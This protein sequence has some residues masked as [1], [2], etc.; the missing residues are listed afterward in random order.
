MARELVKRHFKFPV[1]E[2]SGV[3]ELKSIDEF[4]PVED[5][6]ES[7]N[8]SASTYEKRAVG[9]NKIAS[10]EIESI[11]VGKRLRGITKSKIDELAESISAVGLLQ[12]IVITEDKNLVAG[13]H[14]VEA[15]RQLG[16]IEINAVVIPNLQ[17]QKEIAEIDENLIRNQLTVLEQCEQLKRRKELYEALYPETRR[18]GYARVGFDELQPEDIN[19]N[20][21][22][23]DAF[24]NRAASERKVTPRTIQRAIRI[25][26][27]LDSNVKGQI[28]DLPIAVRF[29]QLMRLAELEPLMQREI[30]AKMS[31]EKLSFP[32]AIKFCKQAETTNYQSDAPNSTTKMNRIVNK[33]TSS[34]SSL[35]KQFESFTLA[36]MQAVI[37][38]LKRERIDFSALRRLSAECGENLA[39]SDLEDDENIIPKQLGMPLT[40]NVAW[41]KN[42]PT[43]DP[44]PLFHKVESDGSRE[45]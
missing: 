39:A 10:V 4:L 9:S 22:V 23:K 43:D 44:L 17:L 15:C 5:S 6:E 25:A 20:R 27:R 12:P 16:I 3:K 37:E 26:E 34:F 32:Q 40:R 7:D 24:S 31:D 30:A 13:L 29:T 8:E 28:S 1:N 11:V 36:E 18:G 41:C 38:Q 14:R 35:L 33:W 21:V 2:K 19:D 45:Q 42:A